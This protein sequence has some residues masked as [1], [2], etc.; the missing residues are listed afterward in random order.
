MQN[1][2][3]IVFNCDENYSPY[4]AV[5]IFSILEKNRDI[6][7]NFYILDLNIREESKK[8]LTNFVESRKCKI[9]FI[10][11]NKK[12]FNKLNTTIQY[13]PD[14]AFARLF[15]HK[16]LPN[17]LEKVLYLDCDIIINQNI[18]E[19]YE[20]DLKENTLGVIIDPFIENIQ[21]KKTINF[22]KDKLYFNSGVLLINFKKWQQ[23]N[24]TD[25]F[26]FFTKKFPNS[27]YLDQDILNVLFQNEVQ[28]LDMRYNFQSYSKA[29][30][31]KKILKNISYPCTMPVAI[32][33]DTGPH[34]AWH[35]KTFNSS[36]IHFE[37][38]FQMFPN[39]PQ[40]WLNKKE[41]NSFFMKAKRICKYWQR[42][43]L[44]GIY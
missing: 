17:D 37:K 21:Y 38:Y 15:L 28:F 19:L 27:Q 42:K 9:N 10:Q 8:S 13:L 6:K 3:N 1:E 26:L 23:K 32:F 29:F 4:L 31:R 14:I 44:Y 24:F 25:F 30:F 16:Y 12:E 33:H 36:A 7:I 34:K 11:V 39:K 22:K 35:A 5:T 40:T 41:K 20:T 43:F 2:M 18:K